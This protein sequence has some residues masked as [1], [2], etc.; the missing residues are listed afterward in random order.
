L[1]INQPN[2]RPKDLHNEYLSLLAKE[3]REFFFDPK[4]N[5]LKQEIAVWVNCPA[6][7]S[8]DFKHYFTKQGLQL[9]TCGQCGLVFMNPR[10]NENSMSEFFSNSEALNKY[11]EMVEITNASRTQLI[12][13]PLAD[14]ILQNFGAGEGRKLI[15]VGCGS[16]LLL[17]AFAK[18]NN[19]WE[20]KGIEPSGG[21]VEI[22]NSKGL[23][24]FHGGIQE[25]EGIAEYDL[26]VFWAVFD[27]FFDPYSII[28]KAQSLLK[29]GGLILIGSMNIE[30]F[31]SMVLGDDN[32]A[33][34][35]P[36][37][38]NF[39]GETSMTAMIKRA[40]FK[41][42]LVTTTGKLDVN[43]IK[44]YWQGG[45]KNGRTH[46]L[47]QL[48]LGKTSKSAAFQEFLMKNNLSGHMTVSAT[49]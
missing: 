37:R 14:F 49:K 21:A 36:E 12:F 27:H 6:C 42:V 43:I 15:E 11:S 2:I 34:T 32:E 7:D 9:H 48:V 30:G 8:S 25:F 28:K 17:D 39:F 10:P 40:G 13:N 33:F 1:K 4:S 24:V 38:Q 35:L 44:E 29:S 18:K 22:C 47:E 19:G 3:I 41:N 20:L 16:G 5:G 23:D 26:V 31:D 46:F 45:G